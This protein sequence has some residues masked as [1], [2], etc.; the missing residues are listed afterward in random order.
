M[1]GDKIMIEVSILIDNLAKKHNGLLISILEDV[2][3]HYNYLPEKVLRAVAKKL[4]LPLRDVYGVA[5]FYSAFS[6]KP[7]G[8]HIMTVCLGTACHVR[9]GQRIVDTISNELDIKPG[10]TTLDMKFTLETV[11]CLG[12]CAIGPILL[13]DGVYHGEMTPRKTLKLLETLSKEVIAKVEIKLN[14]QS[15]V[16]EA[17]V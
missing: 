5:T 11:N 15:P 4:R 9:G 13:V 16:N 12:C 6:L 3:E 1:L 10:E 2:Q 7:K 8:E 17:R 14:L